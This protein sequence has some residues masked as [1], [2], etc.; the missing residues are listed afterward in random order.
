MSIHLRRSDLSDI[1]PL[2]ALFLQEN[3]F[4]IRYN[5]CHQRGWTDTYTVMDG[6]RMIGYGSIKGKENIND[7]DTIFEFYTLPAYRRL[8]SAIFRE[9]LQV[10]KVDF[11]ECQSNEQ[12]LTALLYEFGKDI[13]AEVILFAEN[14]ATRLELV[15]VIFRKRTDEDR[16]FEH[17]LEPVGDYVLEWNREVVA[18]GGFLLHYNPPFADLYM[19]VRADCRKKGLGSFLI[20]ELIKQCYFTGRVPAARTSIHNLASRATL[21]KGGLSIA[22]FMLLGQVKNT[23]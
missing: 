15:E 19:E 23:L 11:I 13:N 22:G 2:R 3:N 12:V 4:Q 10:S 17:Q 21:L 20:Q 1:L 18:T 14:R 6:E 7:R 16:I 9:L 5:A 8:A